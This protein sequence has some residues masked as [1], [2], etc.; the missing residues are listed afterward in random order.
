MMSTLHKGRLR[1]CGLKSVS[2]VIQC[3]QLV[4]P[5]VMLQTVQCVLMDIN[6]GNKTSTL[7]LQPVVMDQTR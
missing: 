2:C 5:Q 4:A 7:V 3:V 1:Y 6:F